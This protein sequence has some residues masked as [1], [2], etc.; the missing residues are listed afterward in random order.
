MTV[1]THPSTNPAQPGLTLALVCLP[2]LF[3][4]KV[5][6][7]SITSN[8]ISVEF[9]VVSP[10]NTIK[11]SIHFLLPGNLANEITYNLI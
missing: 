10:T 4:A 5:P 8:F 9:I 11:G 3:F 1:V 6:F 2:S 7:I